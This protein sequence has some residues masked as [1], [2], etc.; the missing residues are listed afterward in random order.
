MQ[1][2]SCRRLRTLNRKPCR[3]P[4]QRA[5]SES[6]HKESAK[7]VTPQ[8]MREARVPADYAALCAR[9]VQRQEE[10]ADPKTKTR[11]PESQTASRSPLRSTMCPRTLATRRRLAC[12]LRT[13]RSWAGPRQWS[14]TRW[15]M[16][17][18]RIPRRIP[19]TLVSNQVGIIVFGLGLSERMI[20]TR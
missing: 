1:T 12:A 19:S 9:E 10:D 3:A 14:R 18:S 11:N 15:E 20:G 16:F 5:R 8:R 13:R 4:N 6:L 17:Q 7:R 2:A